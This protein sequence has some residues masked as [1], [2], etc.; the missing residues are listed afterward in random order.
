MTLAAVRSDYPVSGR[1]ASSDA[2]GSVRCHPADSGDRPL[3]TS[4]ALGSRV[5]P[6]RRR[7]CPGRHRP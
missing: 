4:G 3:S 2:T 1:V 7:W 5:V 6:G